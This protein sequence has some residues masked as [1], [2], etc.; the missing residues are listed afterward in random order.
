MRWMR[1]VGLL[2]L[3]GGLWAGTTGKITG[4]VV[5]AQTGEPLVGANVVVEGTR[6]GAA[7][8]LDG[9]YLILNVPP[10]NYTLTIS[11]VGYQTKKIQ[12]VVVEADRT[13]EVNVELSP[14]LVQ[15]EV[16]EVIE[17]RITQ[18]MRPD[19][20]QSLDMVKMEDVKT[21]AV[22]SIEDVVGQQAGVVIDPTGNIH[23]RGSRPGEVVYVV[24]GAAV[25][26]PYARTS[27]IE[28]PLSAIQEAS[29]S[30]GG[31]GAEY[32]NAAS[33]VFNIVTRE[34]RERY[35]GSVEFRYRPM[36]LDAERGDRV[37]KK[38]KFYYDIPIGSVVTRPGE[39]D[40]VV[41]TGDG[42]PDV[43]NPDYA[44][45]DWNTNYRRW[46]FALG[47]PFPYLPDLKFYFSGDLLNSDGRFQGFPTN[48][49][50]LQWKVTWTPSTKLKLFTS[51]IYNFTH[52]IP[53]DPQFR[54]A[55]TG[56]F[57]RT[58][59]SKQF[60]L[61]FNYLFNPATYLEV[62][63]ARFVTYLRLNDFEDLDKDGVDDWTDVDGD[64]R[65][66]IDKAW[67]DYLLSIGYISAQRYNE[68]L[69]GAVEENGRYE[70]NAYWWEVD[71]LYPGFVFGRSQVDFVLVD[72][73]NPTTGAQERAYVPAFWIQNN[74]LIFGS[75][76]I[77]DFTIVSDPE[78]DSLVADQYVPDDWTRDRFVWHED[79]SETWSF[80]ADFV[81]AFGRI[82]TF[83][84]GVVFQQHHIWRNRIDYA[85]GGNI[86]VDIVDVKP[87]EFAY[88]IQDKVEYEGLVANLGLRFDYFD[89][90]AL[91]P[92]QLDSTDPS[93]L[94]TVIDFTRYPKGGP[95][96]LD[97]T[98]LVKAKPKWL[99]SPRIG[100]SHPFTDR[101]VLHF[102][103]GYYFQIPQM[104]RLYTNMTYWFTGAFPIIGNPNL[105]PEQTISFEAGFRHAFDPYTMVDITAFQKDIRNLIQS[106]MVTLPNR[107]NV[108]LYQNSDFASSRGVEFEFERL[109]GAPFLPDFSLRANLTLMRAT[110]TFSN[111][112]DRYRLQWAG[113]PL[114]F[115]EELP[116]DWDRPIQLN[117]ILGYRKNFKK[118]LGS[119]LSFQ[120]VGGTITYQ[121]HSGDPWSPPIRDRALALQ[122]TNSLRLPSVST[123][124]L[125]AYLTFG[126]GKIGGIRLYSNI[127]NLLNNRTVIDLENSEYYYAFGYNPETGEHYNPAA[128]EGAVRNQT[129]RQR[130]RYGEVGVE[131]SLQ[132]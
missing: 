73:R 66:E 25:M 127:Y 64:Q 10:G 7:T 45:K 119:D 65:P 130:P 81:S 82:H 113:I 102:T 74:I 2:L 99:V 100:I 95:Q 47:G 48:Q 70:V 37:L 13:S 58:A 116:L 27:D 107:R 4:R 91:Y 54:L 101:D 21:Q 57:L 111:P 31:F 126:L 28:I 20:T 85:S 33:A 62:R 78:M 94:V 80:R 129:N 109:N 35:E 39:I 84:T 40:A 128:A 79:S 29:F 50:G 24:D 92:P 106:N 43:L 11:Y 110:G 123:V 71:G 56:N 15:T 122:Q 18:A 69:Q 32:G 108:T 97:S 125:H 86:Y 34:G 38:A 61:G 87:R 3:G 19:V 98:K 63:G 75:D 5:D 49:D 105:R 55:P 83:K 121:Y 104:A 12:G 77:T 67:L 90:N 36:F 8:D 1:F 120:T 132:Y 103:Y 23:V 115:N 16:V 72:F 44:G 53:Y 17:T 9:Y 42:V 68:L 118:V 52:N 124:D 114:A 93:G 112:T 14:T 59:S 26:D 6:L 117:V 60:V 96:A 46:L 41:R 88:Y 22:Q 51:G 131:I 76:S 30:K 89:P